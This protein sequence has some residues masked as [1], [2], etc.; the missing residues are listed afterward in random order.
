VHALAHRARGALARGEVDRAVGYLT[1]AAQMALGADVERSAPIRRDRSGRAES[2]T[3]PNEDLLVPVARAIVESREPGMATLIDRLPPRPAL[4]LAVY[5]VARDAG[6]PEAD[7]LLERVADSPVRSGPDRDSLDAAARCEALALLGRTEEARE[8]YAAL[9][10]PG[11][12]KPIAAFSWANL[13]ILHAQANEV[14]AMR[15]A[16]EEARRCGLNLDD[17]DAAAPSRGRGGA[18][19]AAH[20]R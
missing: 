4:M 10:V 7:G 18:V 14:D 2:W 6:Q 9:T 12:P 19:T 8:G 5:R 13:A 20:R 15:E 3:L 16:R 1:V 17:E 11:I